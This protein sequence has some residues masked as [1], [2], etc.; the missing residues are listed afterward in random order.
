AFFDGM[1]RVLKSLTGT[2]FQTAASFETMMKIIPEKETG[3]H[4]N[5]RKVALDY[6]IIKPA[7]WC[8]K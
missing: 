1:E 6:G 7:G 3:I 5:L 4:R 8:G 2:E